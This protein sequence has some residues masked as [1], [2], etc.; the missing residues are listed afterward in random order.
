[1]GHPLGSPLH[2]LKNGA[3]VGT[4]SLRRKIQLLQLRPDLEIKD[5]RG[6]ID[7]RLRK[8]E[9][10]EFDGIIL[11]YA[12]IKRL[13]IPLKHF[14]FLP[15]ISAAGQGAIGIE[16]R[17]EEED[18]QDLLKPIH[19]PETA[20]CVNAE[21]AI[22][23]KLEGECELPVGAHAEIVDNKL[24]LR[25]FLANPTGTK[26]IQDEVSGDLVLAESLAESLSEILFSKGAGEI[27]EEM[28]KIKKKL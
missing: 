19:H 22:S 27:L 15:L 26:F 10:K 2:G 20:L 25:G 23:K 6:N 12:G 4:S 9:E 8:L 13:G 3:K 18:L 5:L 24:K 16:I 11:A 17:T 21:R 14:E 1:M 28:R 7:T